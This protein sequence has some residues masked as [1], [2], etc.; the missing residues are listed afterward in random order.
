MNKLGTIVNLL[1]HGSKKELVVLVLF[2]SVSAVVELIFLATLPKAITGIVKN[3][4]YIN[5]FGY[6][7]NS[8][9]VI[10][11]MALFVLIRLVFSYN[12]FKKIGEYTYLR[13]KTI[14]VVLY[15]SVTERYVEKSDPI[16]V[17]RSSIKDVDFITHYLTFPLVSVLTEILTATLLI[18]YI[19]STAPGVLLYLFI[20]FFASAPALY[21]A[22]KKQKAYSK[23]RSANELDLFRLGTDLVRERMLLKSLNAFQ[24]VIKRVEYF[25]SEISR[26]YQGQ[27]SVQNAARLIVEAFSIYLILIELSFLSNEGRSVEFIISVIF[28]QLRL[29]MSASR[30]AGTVQTINFGLESLP[31]FEGINFQSKTAS[32]KKLLEAQGVSPMKNNSKISI[33]LRKNN[34]KLDICGKK[35]DVIRVLG[36]SGSGKSTL[37]RILA[38]EQLDSDEKVQIIIGD[39]EENEN[40]LSILYVSQT[41]RPFNASIAENITLFSDQINTEHLKAVKSLVKL[42]NSDFKDNRVVDSELRTISGGEGQRLIIA[43][44]MYHGGDIVVIDEGFANLPTTEE[45]YLLTL[46]RDKFMVIY[47]T[48]KESHPNASETAIVYEKNSYENS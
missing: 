15:K 22:R 41:T 4:E 2:M 14:G 21:F 26:A 1:T 35:G 48:H 45:H 29:F 5:F 33:S 36:Q 13:Y 30:V 6:A 24:S 9:N 16:E 23:T 44:L 10:W 28:I 32:D 37:L 11:I 43:T 34:R 38:K 12:L 25:F 39:S 7:T 3:D 42:S 19:L 46:L 40:R 31:K 8:V 17:A 18:I 47:T 27:Y 20:L